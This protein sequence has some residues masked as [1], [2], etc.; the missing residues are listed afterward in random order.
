MQRP[1]LGTM[2]VLLLVVAL[3]GC[4]SR[5]SSG[6]PTTTPSSPSVAPVAPAPTV[7]P[8]PTP[9]AALDVVTE[10][11]SLFAADFNGSALVAR[12]GAV[13][14][15]KGF[16]MA[17]DATSLA[18]TAE[19][20]FRIASLTK[21]FT[22]MA[23]LQLES[24][25]EI[26]AS[27]SICDYLDTCPTGWDAITIE[28][29]LGHTS[30]IADFTEQPDFDPLQAATPAETVASVSDIPLPRTPGTSFSYTNTGYIL[31]GMVIERVSGTSYEAFMQDEI[32]A[33]LGMQDSG[34]EHGDTPGLATGYVDGFTLADPI[35]MSMPY[36]AGGLYSTVLDLHRWEE[37]LYTDALAPAAD[38][39]R[40]FAPLVESTDH[41]PFAYAYGQY[42]GEDGASTL[43]W[44]NGGING[45]YSQLS[46]YPDDHITVALLT[47]REGS[48]D[49]LSLSQ[50]AARAARQ[51]P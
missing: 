10:L 1:V 35:D 29:L 41:A 30:G 17:D 12:D 40:F 7:P 45:F 9:T 20:R 48:P 44:G 37:A 33:P 34:Y 23:I 39:A 32:F 47:N 21:Q 27:D 19:T 16:G 43:V 2:T 49:L 3:V 36:A 26:M 22:A 4:A 13:L 8:T 11:D 5:A 42:V 51:M 25:E 50:L 46:R 18:N 6:V 38:M 31:L 28:H 15:A 24:R 14:Y